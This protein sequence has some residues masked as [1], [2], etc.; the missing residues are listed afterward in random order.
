MVLLALAIGYTVRANTR[1]EI[2]DRMQQQVKLHA[3]DVTAWVHEKQRITSAIQLAVQR[4]D[5]TD[6]LRTIK[7]AGGFDDAFMVF[8]DNRL[9]FL[10]PVPEGYNGP[11]RAWYKQA[12]QTG[13]PAI[14]PAYVEASHGELTI[15]F[16]EPAGAKDKPIGAFGTD[17]RLSSLSRT[18]EAIRPMD[19]SFAFLVDETGNLLAYRDARLLLKPATELATGLDVTT[20]HALAQRQLPGEVD[21]DGIGRL[22]YASPV[23][24]TPWTLAVVIDRNLAMQPV[25]EV[26]KVTVVTALVASLLAAALLAPVLSVQLRRLARVR[27]ALQEIASGEGDLTHRLSVDG[28]DELAHIGDAFNQFADKI[29]GVLRQ[30]REA[31]GS[32]RIAAGEIA[33]GNQ[34]LS[35]RTE[36]QAGSVQETAAAMEQLTGTVQQNAERARLASEVAQSASTVASDGGEVV[37]QVVQTM[38]AISASSTR[39]GD[40]IGVID[41]IAFQTNILALNA[42]VEAA[43]AGEQGRGFAVVASEVRALAQRSALA[44]KEIKA[45]IDTSV[46][47]VETGSRLVGRAG[48]TMQQILISV[49]K[50]TQLIGE[51]SSAS[52]EQ[53]TGISEISGAVQAMDHATQ[54]NAALVEQAMAAAQSLDQQADSLARAVAGFR[55]EANAGASFGN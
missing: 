52:R 21:I 32:V 3:D 13:G 12:I 38:D 44:A 25:R 15:S 24:G 22:V 48:N 36:R 19:N 55:L 26:L 43:R 41:G 9:A 53:S 47:Q 11:E 34:D 23:A 18:I 33:A 31:T 5:L 30:I 54:Q 8:A 28:H 39:V 17:M 46:E 45:L 14:T 35:A 6:F 29:A 7:Q 40:I 16:V 27:D 4:P 49:R 10:G 51:I 20:L 37:D 42:A 2:N 1:D 50:V